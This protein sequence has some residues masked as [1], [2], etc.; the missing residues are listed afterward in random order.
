MA[1]K[2]TLDIVVCD[3]KAKLTSLPNHGK[4]YS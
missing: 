2:E 1:K 4:T 3:G